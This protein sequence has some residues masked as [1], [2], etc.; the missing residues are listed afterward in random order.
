MRLLFVFF[1][2]TNKH[3]LKAIGLALI[4]FG[5]TGLIIDYFSKELSVGIDEEIRFKDDIS[6][7]NLFY[8]NFGVSY[9]LIKNLKISLVYR[10]IEKFEADNTFSFRNRLMLDIGY[11]YKINNLTLSY[12][13]RIQSELRNYYSS[14]KG[15][16]TRM[17]LAQ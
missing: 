8:T 13:N 9:K 16:I 6:R 7:L 10:L 12:R 4:I 15:E 5:L 2:F 17:V 11:K 14:V 1:L 3:V